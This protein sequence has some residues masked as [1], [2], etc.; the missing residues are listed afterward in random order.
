MKKQGGIAD[1][2]QAVDYIYVA[3]YVNGQNIYVDG[4]ANLLTI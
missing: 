3:K 4:G 1:I 2:I